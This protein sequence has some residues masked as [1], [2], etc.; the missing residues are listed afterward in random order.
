M[1]LNNGYFCDNCKLD[2]SNKV[3][4]HSNEKFCNLDF[5]EKCFNENCDCEYDKFFKPHLLD[6]TKREWE[7]MSKDW[8][9]LNCREI[10]NSNSWNKLSLK[11]KVFY[12]CN[13]CVDEDDEEY[14]KKFFTKI[15]SDTILLESPETYQIVNYTDFPTNQY[16]KIATHIPVDPKLL[17]KWH[18]IA[19]IN[20]ISLIPS[21]QTFGKIVDWVPIE[22]VSPIHH[23]NST[24]LII[25]DSQKRYA[26]VVI[27]DRHKIFIE[28]FPEYENT[29][30]IDAYLRLKSYT[31]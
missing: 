6:Y 29:V 9:C 15:P 3:F 14:L 4:F 27:D 1:N 17:E 25:Q 23:T 12:V 18:N 10:L 30:D 26:S 24:Y 8:I 5:C 16:I 21:F 20:D 19:Y 28:Y 13:N 2:L 7:K 22:K 11:D 31:K